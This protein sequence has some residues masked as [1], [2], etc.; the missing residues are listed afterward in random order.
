ML[1]PGTAIP[2]VAVHSQ[3][4]GRLFLPFADAT[5]DVAVP[6]EGSAAY[7]DWAST[8]P[9]RE[10]YT[11]LSAIDPDWSTAITTSFARLRCR[12]P[13]PTSRSGMTVRCSGW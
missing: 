10:A 11:T 6:D 5:F 9:N 13:N 7:D 3:Y 1:M 4:R 12:R 2:I 8:A